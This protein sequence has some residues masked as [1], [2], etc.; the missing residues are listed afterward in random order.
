LLLALAGAPP[1]YEQIFGVGKMKR[2]VMEAKQG[3][4]KGIFAVKLCEILCGSGRSAR[5]PEVDL[6]KISNCTLQCFGVNLV[7]CPKLEL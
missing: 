7:S 4:N 1:T 5:L 3:S 6:L 2:D